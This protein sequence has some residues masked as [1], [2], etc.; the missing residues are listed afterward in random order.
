LSA[1]DADLEKGA[2]RVNKS[3]MIRNNA[4]AQ[5]N[6]RGNA[7]NAT[8]IVVYLKKHGKPELESDLKIEDVEVDE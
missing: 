1:I 6:F 2:L 4:F 5:K 7:D 3:F 8:S